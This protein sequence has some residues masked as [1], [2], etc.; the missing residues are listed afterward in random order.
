[1]VSIKESWEKWEV[2][3]ADGAAFM[4]KDVIREFWVTLCPGRAEQFLAGFPLIL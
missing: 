2:V 3:E 1:M 4:L